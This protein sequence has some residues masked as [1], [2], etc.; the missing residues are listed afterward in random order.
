MPADSRCCRG[1]C[2]LS[3]K[4]KGTFTPHVETW[5]LFWSG[6]LGGVVWVSTPVDTHN[7]LTPIL[8]FQSSTKKHKSGFRTHLAIKGTDVQRSVTIWEV[9]RIPQNKTR[10]TCSGFNQQFGKLLDICGDHSLICFTELHHYSFGSACSH[11]VFTGQMCSVLLQP[12]SVGR[13]R[14][15]R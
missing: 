12:H 13:S 4:P 6:C 11:L 14:S 8:T 1:S 15:V 3:P 9:T 10:Y 2:D 7:S 5:T